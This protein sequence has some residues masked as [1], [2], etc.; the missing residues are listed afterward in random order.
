MMKRTA[1]Y[2]T[3]QTQAHKKSPGNGV[4]TVVSDMLLPTEQTEQQT[5]QK[6][7]IR[8]LPMQHDQGSGFLL[9]VFL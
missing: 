6:E 8:G 9:R 2:Q 7:V 1:Y 4:G 3:K 5:V